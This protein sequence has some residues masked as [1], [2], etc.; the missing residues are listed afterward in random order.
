MPQ[1]PSLPNVPQQSP[2]NN[3]ADSLFRNVTLNNENAVTLNPISNSTKANFVIPTQFPRVQLP[4]EFR[5]PP[6]QSI[7][8]NAS[9]STNYLNSAHMQSNISATSSNSKKGAFLKLNFLM[10]IHKVIK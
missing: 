7:L 6:P 1:L 8:P 5:H 10:I 3:N 2:I 4:E 9:N